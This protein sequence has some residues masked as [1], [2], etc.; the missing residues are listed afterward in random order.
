MPL[1]E[2][3]LLH[4]NNDADADADAEGTVDVVN[5]VHCFLVLV[6]LIEIDHMN[7]DIGCW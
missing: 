4:S 2:E 1:L 3:W 5:A 7:D 6:L